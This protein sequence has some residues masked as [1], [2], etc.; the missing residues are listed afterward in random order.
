MLHQAD[1]IAGRLLGRYQ[2]SDA[3]NALKTGYDPVAQRWPGGLA[4]TGVRCKLLPEVG[5]PGRI[6]GPLDAIGAARLGLPA[7][8]S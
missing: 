6:L 2:W 3:N 1:W 4:A 8:R 7:T 5:P